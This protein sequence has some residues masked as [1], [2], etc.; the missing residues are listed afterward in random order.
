MTH[1]TAI[2]GVNY[3]LWVSTAGFIGYCAQ[4]LAATVPRLRVCAKITQVTDSHGHAKQSFR[5]EVKVNLQQPRSA[6]L[7]PIQKIPTPIKLLMSP[8]P[9]MINQICKKCSLENL[10]DKK[11]SDDTCDIFQK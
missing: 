3:Q 2:F 11:T 6:R 7:R 9:E 10:Q 1:E 4:Q 8:L 5:E